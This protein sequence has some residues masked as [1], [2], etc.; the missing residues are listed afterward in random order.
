MVVIIVNL[1]MSQDGFVLLLAKFNLSQSLW[2]QHLLAQM[3]VHYL[4][5]IQTNILTHLVFSVNVNLL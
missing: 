1:L 5:E 3:F 2:L 4:V